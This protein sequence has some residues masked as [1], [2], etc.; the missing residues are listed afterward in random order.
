MVHLVGV[1]KE[2]MVEVAEDR[3]KQA[4]SFVDILGVH[5]KTERLI[6]ILINE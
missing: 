4:E 1:E 5:N 2:T 6:E 3:A